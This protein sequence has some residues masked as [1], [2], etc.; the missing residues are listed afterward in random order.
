[1]VPEKSSSLSPLPALDNQ[2]RLPNFLAGRSV[3]DRYGRLR[4]C[5]KRRAQLVL[6]EI[7]AKSKF[8]NENWKIINE[9][10]HEAFSHICPLQVRYCG[11]SISKTNIMVKIGA[12]DTLA[13]CR[14]WGLSSVAW[15]ANKGL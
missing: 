10:S 13:T 15:S 9:P 2:R 12:L 6:V 14:G 8:W 11:R 1:M 5:R 3:A 7:I 4:H